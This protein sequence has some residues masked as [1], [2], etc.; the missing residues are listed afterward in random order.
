M[1]GIVSR[2]LKCLLARKNQEIAFLDIRE[3]GEYGMGHPFHAVNVPFSRLESLVGQLVPR[4]GTPLVVMDDHGEGR[5]RRAAQCLA[6]LGYGDIAYLEG[7]VAAWR[8]SG[9]GLFAGVNVISKTFGELVHEH[10]QPAGIEASTLAEWQRQ[11]RPVHIIDGRPIAEYRKMNIPSSVCCP[12]GELAK[13]LPTLLEGDA[14]TPVVVNCAGRTR[15]IIGAQTLRWLGIENPVYALENGTQGWRLAGLTLEHGSDRGYPQNT[16]TKDE[17]G[18]AARR[19]AGSRDVMAIGAA[20]LDN[21]LADDRRTTYVFDIRTEEEYLQDSLP[22]A[23]HA[24]G[25]QLI[26]ATDHWVGVRHARLVLIDD[27]ECRAPLVASWLA[28]MG[29]DVA[30]LR[31]GRASWSCLR[32]LTKRTPGSMS[33]PAPQTVDLATALEPTTLCLDARP[34]MQYR[35]GHLPGARWVNR[36]LLGK[37]L[38]ED[39][40]HRPVVIVAD[41][42]RAACL[43]SELKAHG[44]NRIGW[45]VPAFDAWASEGIALDR[46]PNEPDDDH[47]IDFLF[48]VHDRHDGNLEASRRYL[49]WE[50]GL[51][52]QLDEQERSTFT[53]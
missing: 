16:E 6:D 29:M 23:V 12:N 28:L 11:G 40:I 39:D 45:L 5:A 48:F 44:V 2:D 14:S 22:G 50:T 19:L 13:R 38:S 43:A 42:E 9:Y 37:Q 7:G 24:P 33:P 10:F 30:W 46:T 4:L 51:L 15:S 49:A 36:S 31:G 18:A 17:L 41:E 26:Q 34:G 1:H 20:T 53:L 32:N 47:C 27:D 35:E 8:E 3:F 21:W 25:G 52:A